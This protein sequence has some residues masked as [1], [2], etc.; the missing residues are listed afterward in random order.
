M[1][2]LVPALLFLAL[3]PTFARAQEPKTGV[4]Q[5]TITTQGT[6]RLPG[7]NV[8]VKDG[9]DKHVTEMLSG[10]DGHFSVVGLQPGRYSV[11][12]SLESFIATTVAAEVVA[13]RST[14]ITIDLPI[15]GIAASVE[16]VASNPILSSEGTV[17]QTETIG[18]KEIDQFSS[19]GGVEAS[20]KLLAGVIQTPNGVSIRGGRPSQAGMQLGVTTLADPS[21]GLSK[22]FLP[23]DAIESVSVLPN[24]YAVE[25]GR[26]S[27]GVVVIQTRRAGDAWRMTLNDIEPTF[28][29]HRGSPVQV[30]GLGWYAPRVEFGGPIVKDRLFIQQAAQFRYQASDVPSLPET[31]LHTSTSFSSFTRVDANLTPRHTL[32]ATLGLFPGKTH[33]DLLGTFMPPNA[34]VDTH[35]NAHE[36][37]VTERALW[38]D[39][40]FGETTFHVHRYQTDVY[41]QGAAPMR[42]LPG[43]TLGN[44]YNEQHRDTD[45]YQLI[46]TVSGSYTG[47][48]GTHLFKVGLDLLRNEYDGSSLSRSVLVERTDGTL[49]RSLTYAAAPATQ[50]VHTTDV[51]LFAQDRFQPNAR[52]Y[53]EFGGRIDRDGVT[54][55]FNVTPRI[56]TAVLLNKSG[57]SVLR[58]GFGLFYERTPSTAGAF[59]EFGGVLDQRYAADGL[60]PLGPAI[61]FVDTS[62]PLETPRSRTWDVGLDHRVNKYWTIHL[63]LLDRQ[64]SHELIV[65]P[66]AN[67][68]RR[69]VAVVERRPV[70]LPRSRSGRALHVGHACGRERVVHPVGG[71]RRFELAVELLRHHHVARLRRQCVRGDA[72]RRTEPP[73]LARPLL[74]HAALAGDWPPRLARRLSVLRDQR[75]PRLRRAPE[76]AAFS[77]LL[78]TRS[79]PRT[80]LQDS[81]IPAV[82]RRPRVECPA[83][84]P[85]DRRAVEPQF[86]RVR[87]VLQLRVSA[88]P[89][90]SALRT[91]IA[92]HAIVQSVLRVFVLSWFAVVDNR[93]RR[94]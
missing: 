30:I 60:T 48:G 9:A 83:I 13:G 24:P 11:L 44:F 39:T 33:M 17:S 29:T 19:G 61:D 12:A 85:A 23:A 27:S 81:Q 86:A 72:G 94:H 52:W 16:V 36:I 2:S 64:S 89:H 63:G 10:E 55:Q 3:S 57:S 79:R 54:K 31:L 93:Y 78:S 73:A 5:G 43:T 6:V 41:P 49:A 92:I 68:R 40:L 90:H 34:T 1:R 58:G 75:V 42:L 87:H 38:T 14:D 69:P 18:G 7:A 76:R 45:S 50:R 88:D 15:A 8:V 80:P 51:A 59:T 65:E 70:E 47:M 46:E 67:G 77:H 82:D 37:A 62:A 53:V 91:M 35:L 4:I 74:S 56:G 71:P 25:F 66:G 32:V 22:V 20:L 21:T 84:V 26:F 28:R